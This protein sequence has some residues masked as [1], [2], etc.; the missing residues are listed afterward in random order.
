MDQLIISLN[1]IRNYSDLSPLVKDHE[2]QP[3]IRQAQLTRL[4]PILCPE[5]YNALLG[6]I[7]NPTQP[8]TDLLQ[9]VVPFLVFA[10]IRIYAPQARMKHGPAGFKVIEDINSSQAPDNAIK[11]YIS[12]YEEMEMQARLELINYMEINKALFP[13]WEN[14]DCRCKD[15]TVMNGFGFIG[16]RVDDTDTGSGRVWLNR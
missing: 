1:D 7:S 9:Y 12:A 13:A 4:K 8:Y 5:T 3:Y 15:R 10:T 16:S 6:M 11:D 14:S 2:M